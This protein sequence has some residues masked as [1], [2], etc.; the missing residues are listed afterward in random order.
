MIQAHEISILV[1]AFAISFSGCDGVVVEDAEDA[2]GVAV[3][4]VEG[5]GA[6]E[7]QDAEREEALPDEDVDR[8]AAEEAEP[9]A[10]YCTSYPEG[11]NYCLARCGD[12]VWRVVGHL[13]QIPYGTCEAAGINFCSW[14]GHGA[15]SGA[16]WGWP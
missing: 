16:C 6:E 11:G 9:S 1:A 4:D 10:A 12:G 8:L 2:D 7:V 3:E 5:D 14:G 13:S 15:H